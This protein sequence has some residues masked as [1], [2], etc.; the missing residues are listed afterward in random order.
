MSRKELR[1]L[2]QAGVLTDA[3]VE[4]VI[5]IEFNP[6]SIATA[7]IAHLIF[8]IF[9]KCGGLFKFGSQTWE[10]IDLTYGWLI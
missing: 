1:E 4:E 9:F 2:V 10:S 3:E 6:V 7:E 8:S 5:S